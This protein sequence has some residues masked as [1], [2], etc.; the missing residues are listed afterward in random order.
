MKV[1]ILRYFAYG[2]ALLLA[3]AVGHSFGNAPLLQKVGAYFADA[4]SDPKTSAAAASAVFALM[5]LA[6]QYL[7]GNKQAAAVASRKSH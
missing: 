5:S 1:S 7:V 3:F 6:V 4:L 2:A